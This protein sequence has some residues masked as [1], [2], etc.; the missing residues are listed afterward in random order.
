MARLGDGIKRGH[1]V[2]PPILQ[3]SIKVYQARGQAAIV[4]RDQSQ[5]IFA[6]RFF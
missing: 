4:R 3:V 2:V 5:S 6:E 1:L